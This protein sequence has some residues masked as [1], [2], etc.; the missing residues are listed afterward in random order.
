MTAGH[1]YLIYK[2]F[3]YGRQLYKYNAE[4]QVLY[5]EWLVS[6]QGN[7]YTGRIWPETKIR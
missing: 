2:W 5:W 1:A 6:F 3:F 7:I 4:Q